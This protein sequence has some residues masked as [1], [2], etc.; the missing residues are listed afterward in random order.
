MDAG[1]TAT[2]LAK[3]MNDSSNR[4]VLWSLTGPG[5]LSGA[6][7]LAV[8]YNAPTTNLSFA[9]QATITARSVADATKNAAVQ[10]TVNPYPQI[11]FQTLPNGT[12]GMAYSQPIVAADFNGD[13]KL[14][15]AIANATD[16]TV[17]ILLQQ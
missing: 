14:D 5:S 9:E 11:P 3:V 6:S 2:L 4:G 1:Q 16:W 8:T 10:F 15:L 17:S 7:G 12:V 13:G